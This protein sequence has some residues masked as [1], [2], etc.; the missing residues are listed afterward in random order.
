M[1]AAH[2]LAADYYKETGVSEIPT[3]RVQAR[4]PQPLY[5]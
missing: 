1:Q 2:L 3:P 5:K 4:C